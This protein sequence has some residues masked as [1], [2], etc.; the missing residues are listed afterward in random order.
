MQQITVDHLATLDGAHI[1]DVRE[2]DEFAAGHVPGATN[3]PLSQLGD[4][5]GEVPTD[6]PVY[7]ICELGGRSARATGTLTAAGV[8]AI[9][10]AGG[11]AAWRQA[12][13]PVDAA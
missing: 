11:T 8:D 13:H 9:D 10:I 1:L 3:L 12:G 4:R 2:P 7:V 5:V 6:G